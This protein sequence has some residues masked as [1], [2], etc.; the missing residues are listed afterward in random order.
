VPTGKPTVAPAGEQ[1][2]ASA[3]RPPAAPARNEHLSNIVI[4]TPSGEAEPVR[5]KL[6]EH[7]LTRSAELVDDNEVHAL[8][9]GNP[10][11]VSAAIGT[12]FAAGLTVISIE[13]NRMGLEELFMRITQKK[14]SKE[15][16]P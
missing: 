2:T 16:R 15:K 11:E 14:S 12:V 8:I 7:P 9:G 13:Q 3:G 1:S 5:L 4:K 10:A 6:L